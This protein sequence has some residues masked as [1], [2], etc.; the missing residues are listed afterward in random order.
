MDGSGGHHPGGEAEHHHAGRGFGADGALQVGRGAGVQAVGIAHAGE[1]ETA[2]D[3]GG[4][5]HEGHHQDLHEDETTVLTGEET[6]TVEAVGGEDAGGDGNGDGLRGDAAE[7]AHGLYEIRFARADEHDA[8]EE[9]Q[10]TEP[11]GDGH[12]VDAAEEITEAG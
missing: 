10:T 6:E 5:G 9:H 4:I 1:H 2:R 7:S 3:E 8:T 12:H 11:G